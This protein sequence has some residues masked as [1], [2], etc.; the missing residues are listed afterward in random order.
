M[1]RQRMSSG[2][3]AYQSSRT[4]IITLVHGTWGRGF[5]PRDY[6]TQPQSW[7]SELFPAAPPWLS[8]GSVF[9]RRDDPRYDGPLRG[10]PLRRQPRSAQGAVA[11]RQ[12]IDLCRLQD[13]RHR[14]G[15]EPRTW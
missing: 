14:P 13:D 3:S 9:L 5:F 10:T 2:H 8:E 15:P 4:C 12:R 6:E 7:W 11:D 1:D